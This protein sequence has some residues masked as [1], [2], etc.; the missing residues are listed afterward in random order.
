[1]PEFKERTVRPEEQIVSGW[2]CPVCGGHQQMRGDT[3]EVSMHD[4]RFHDL[5]ER[6][7]ACEKR[8][9]IPREASVPTTEDKP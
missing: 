2:P 3:V 6:I 8:L 4:Q 1:M 9:G 7:E 5:L